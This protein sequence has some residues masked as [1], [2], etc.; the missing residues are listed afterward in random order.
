LEFDRVAGIVVVAPLE[1]T[2]VQEAVQEVSETLDDAVA[3]PPPPT[4]PPLTAV[5]I[6]GEELPS[7]DIVLPIKKSNNFHRKN[8]SLDKKLQLIADDHVL[9]TTISTGHNISVRWGKMSSVPAWS[10][11]RK[12]DPTTGKIFR[13]RAELRKDNRSMRE[14][15]GYT[16]Y[17]LDTLKDLVR[18]MDKQ[19]FFTNT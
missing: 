10:N 3:A 12:Y 16:G 9:A 2:V 1:E 11:G 13:V 15:S 18:E 14:L 19:G 17:A 5:T 6:S 4:S 8:I 7:L